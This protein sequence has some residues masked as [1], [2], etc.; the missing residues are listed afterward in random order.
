MVDVWWAATSLE[1]GRFSGVDVRSDVD[2][3]RHRF[4]E[5]RSR[6]RGYLEVR[7]NEHAPYPA[8]LLGFQDEQAVLHLHRDETRMSLLLGDR[9]RTSAVVDV[10]V[11]DDVV[12]FSAAFALTLDDAWSVVDAFAAGDAMDGHEW[13]DL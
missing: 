1:T 5:L 11:M 12:E 13:D 2:E 7:R 9:A 8:V 4:D 6:G 10:L 3:L